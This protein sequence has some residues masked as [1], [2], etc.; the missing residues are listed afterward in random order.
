MQLTAIVKH[1]MLAGALVQHNVTMEP[2]HMAYYGQE[3]FVA[4]HLS[5]WWFLPQEVL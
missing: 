3:L 4:A 1:F 2:P 5:S